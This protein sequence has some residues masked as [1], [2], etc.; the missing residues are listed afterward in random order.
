[1]NTIVDFI[2]YMYMPKM[3]FNRTVILCAY[4]LIIWLCKLTKLICVIVYSWVHSIPI[5]P[6]TYT[7]FAI[8]QLCAHVKF[9]ISSISCRVRTN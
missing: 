3:R 5:A 1:M 7:N 8:C 2:G 4:A 6:H 9:T